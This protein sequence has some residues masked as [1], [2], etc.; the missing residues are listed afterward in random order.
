MNLR[1]LV[2]TISICLGLA[3]VSSAQ[4]LPGTPASGTS[5]GVFTP[6]R[7]NGGGGAYTDS[8]GQ[9]WSADTDFSGGN[10]FS[11]KSSIRNT[12]DSG[13]YQTERYGSFSYQFTVPNGN[14]NVVLK[15]AELYWTVAGK[16][17]F[18]VSIDGTEVLANFDIVAAAGAPLTAIDKTFPV[19]VT[20]GTVKIQFLRGSV[21]QPKVSAIQIVQTA[22]LPPPP[23]GQLSLSPTN[24]AFG[25]VN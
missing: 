9:T 22:G 20:G 12:P 21:D 15:F 24:F 16:R 8:Q 11:T 4:P 5:A 6:I 14:Y 7:V 23:Q 2:V 17:I 19:T 1:N 13:L 25:K 3:G 18:N 10:V